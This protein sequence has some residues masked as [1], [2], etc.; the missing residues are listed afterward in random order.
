MSTCTAD[1]AQQHPNRQPYAAA[2]ASLHLGLRPKR[3][4]SMFIRLSRVNSLTAIRDTSNPV[5]TVGPLRSE[6]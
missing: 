3:Q 5:S 4:C 6:A 2:A 1:K